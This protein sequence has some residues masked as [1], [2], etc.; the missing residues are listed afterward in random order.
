MA[1][2]KLA[3]ADLASGTGTSVYTCPASIYTVANVSFCNRGTQPVLI[4]LSI[5]DSATPT[6]GE[7]LEWETELLPKNV[8]ERTGLLLAAT[9]R[10]VARAS[11]ANVS[12]VVFGI[13][14]I[15]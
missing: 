10:L 8:L 6:A 11:A 13:E 9:Q 15:A 7:Y 3:A 5:S 14:T 12:C 4:R 1:T 2:G